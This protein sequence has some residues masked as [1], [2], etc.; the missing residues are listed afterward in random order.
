MLCAPF[1]SRD[2]FL[3]LRLPKT[4]VLIG[5]PPWRGRPRDR[6]DAWSIS[7]DEQVVAFPFFLFQE[8]SGAQRNGNKSISKY[9]RYTPVISFF[10]WAVNV[11]YIFGSDSAPPY[12][13]IVFLFLRKRLT[14][15]FIAERILCLFLLRRDVVSFPF[16]S[17]RFQTRKQRTP[18]HLPLVSE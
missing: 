11:S 1:V 9:L 8:Q 3:I 10:S 4:G 12:F 16:L 15:F 14:S 2:L 13:C 6:S 17:F 5:F 18:R 7:M